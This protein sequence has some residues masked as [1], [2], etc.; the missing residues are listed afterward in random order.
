MII[1]IIISFLAA[2]I[3]SF[4]GSLQLGPVNL[5][6]IHVAQ[7]RGIKPALT[8][9]AGGILPEIFYTCCA[10]WFSVWFMSNEKIFFLFRVIS[11]PVFLIAGIVIYF[12]NP[13]L[14]RTVQ[15]QHKRLFISG[16]VTGMF[17]PMLFTFWFMVINYITARN[18]ILIGKLSNGVAFAM[19]AAAGAFLLLLLFALIAEKKKS[20][21][22][23]KLNG[24]IHKIIGVVFIILA[25]TEGIKLLA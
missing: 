17:N 22:S 8:V 21:L 18:F 4:I 16:L 19:G 12:R 23:H 25:A 6:V 7:Q 13:A 14:N 3:I 2:C 5:S 20:V 1:E 24:S 10:L 15:I 9:A 11:V